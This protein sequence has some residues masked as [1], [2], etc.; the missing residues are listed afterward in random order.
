M[1]LQ[2]KDLAA[3]R[4]QTLSFFEQMANIGSEIER[5]ISWK[6]KK[7]SEYAQRAFERALELIDLTI[8]DN[9][10]KSRLREIVRVREALADFFVFDN[11][12]NTT[13][14]QWQKYFLSFTFAA[15]A[16]R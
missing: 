1:N 15:R 2:H 5:T 14:Q 9:R 8:L 6:R 11:V 10:N 7:S 16:K 3:G 12:Y 4:W 13:S